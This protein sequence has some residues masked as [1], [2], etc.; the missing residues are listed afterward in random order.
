MPRRQT[1]RTVV[2]GRHRQQIAVFVV[3]IHTSHERSQIPTLII[4]RYGLDRLSRTDIVPSLVL[5]RQVFH[6]DFRLLVC[7]LLDR[8]QESQTQSMIFFEGLVIEQQIF[9][10]VHTTVVTGIDSTRRTTGTVRTQRPVELVAVPGTYVD[11]DIRTVFNIERKRNI[12]IITSQETVF[13][14]LLL[15]IVQIQELVP[16]LGIIPRTGCNQTAVRIIDISQRIHVFHITIQVTPVISV[17][18]GKRGRT[19]DFDKSVQRPV[20]IDT[21]RI[22]AIILPFHNSV[23]S[24]ISRG[25]QH[26]QFF[27]SASHTDFVVMDRSRPQHLICPAIVRQTFRTPISSFVIGLFYLPDHVRVRIEVT[28]LPVPVQCRDERVGS[29]LRCRPVCFTYQI[30]PFSPIKH[31]YFTGGLLYTHI[32]VIINLD[33]SLLSFFSCHQDHA[34][35]S[36]RTVDGR[37]GSIFQDLDRFDIRR[38]QFV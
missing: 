3:I 26:L 6:L 8:L 11:T 1:G 35:G 38:A 12:Q 13:L 14:Y 19:T 16:K 37:C 34:I 22:A 23:L 31:F 7:F 4:A 9:P 17:D 2:T 25:S 32:A 27:R 15:H 10:R 5:V 21:D 24:E 33:S 18:M 36:T 20:K 28:D 29:R 30:Y